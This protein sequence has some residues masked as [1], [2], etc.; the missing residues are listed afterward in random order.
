MKKD[1]YNGYRRYMSPCPFCGGPADIDVDTLDSMPDGEKE[2]IVVGCDTNG[3]RG[4]IN[5]QQTGHPSRFI[6]REIDR[7]NRRPSDLAAHCEQAA[8][9][10]ATWPEWKRGVLGYSSQ[11]TRQEPRQPVDNSRDGGESRGQ[12]TPAQPPP[13]PLATDPADIRAQLLSPEFITAFA[14]AFAVEFVRTPFPSTIEAV[15]GTSAALAENQST[16]HS[17][18]LHTEQFSTQ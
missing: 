16:I 4:S 17:A 2:F 3:C 5:M 1:I 12:Q 6:E 9:I 13:S 7:W 14:K 18:S 10:V 8:A 11:P 15:P